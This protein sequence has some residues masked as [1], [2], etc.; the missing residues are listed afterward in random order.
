M[1][2]VASPS[3]WGAL[4]AVSA[5]LCAVFL[6]DGKV[7][8][9]TFQIQKSDLGQSLARYERPA[10]SP[11]DSERP[12]VTAV[13]LNWARLAN[14]V[15]IVTLL[16]GDVLENIIQEVVVFNNNYSRPLVD[17]DFANCNC[18]HRL[19][20]HNSP[21]NLYFQAR[22]M[23]CSNASTPY[24]FIQ[25]DDYLIKPE[26]IRSLRA[27]IDTHDIFVLPPDEVLSSHLL[28]INSP[29]TNITFGFSWLGYGAL[30][31][32]S[33]A[34]SFLSL[35]KR[36]GA[37]DEEIKMA[38]NYYSILANRFPEIWTS[39]PI[40]LF[41]GGAFT[42]GAEG[43]ARNRRHIAAAANYLDAIASNQSPG[44]DD[45]PYVSPVSS[46]LGP[47]RMERSPCLERSCVIESTIQ[48]LPD[49]FATDT[50]K[51]AGELFSREEQLSMMLT[52]QFISNY[53]N[54]PLSYAVD[55]DPASFFRS[56]WNV[57][58][59]DMLVLD[60]FDSVQQRNWTDVEW[61]WVVDADTAHALR[62]STYSH[63]SDRQLWV[64]SSGTV[65]CTTH[66][67]R[68]SVFSYA[69]LECHIPMEV[70][71][72]NSARYFRL[73]LGEPGIICPWLIYDTWL[74]GGAT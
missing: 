54:F 49:L 41:G 3:S 18:S 56:A 5:A 17:E 8:W 55:A 14:V 53:V 47:P 15:Q 35:L 42:V 52:E 6:F 69:A 51:T 62:A 58:E 4:L 65:S 31:L 13:L 44:N 73:Q 74:H 36:I 45:W 1:K 11:L 9:F 37:S 59:G 63:S 29:S 71:N 32:R 43:V 10:N 19:R 39:A 25:D 30:I 40:P 33:H 50:Y 64:Q 61:W 23:A 12:D 34:E 7:H 60:V 28:S 70:S 66:L 38:D 21:E 46:Q 24:C 67:P 68:D 16:C 72:L 48:Y 22:F 20:I 57:A 26:I 2:R 27:R